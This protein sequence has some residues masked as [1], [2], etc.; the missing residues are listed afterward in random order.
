MGILRSK[1][2]SLQSPL[3][4]KLW[5]QFSMKSTFLVFKQEWLTQ[6]GRHVQLLWSWTSMQ[7]LPCVIYKGTSRSWSPSCHVLFVSPATTCKGRQTCWFQCALLKI[8][9]PEVLYR[10]FELFCKL[11]FWNS[12]KHFF[13]CKSWASLVVQLLRISLATQGTLVWFLV[14]RI[15]H[16]TEQLSLCTTNTESV[17]L[18]PT[19]YNYWAHTLQLLKPMCLELGSAT[20]EDITMRSLRS[21]TE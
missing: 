1:G 9:K 17:A 21:A 18:Q 16:A 6:E 12:F 15:P 5:C 4:I 11:C 2:C 3:V 8:V 20:W 7:L 10:N 13:K 19:S 14:W